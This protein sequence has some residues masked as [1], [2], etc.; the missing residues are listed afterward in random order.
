[1]DDGW[2]AHALTFVISLLNPLG[3]NYLWGE[4]KLV[5]GN[6]YWHG[7]SMN[8]TASQF[9]EQLQQGPV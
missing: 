7:S 8:H 9:A 3:S 5:P 6:Y 2:N 4:Q 1:M